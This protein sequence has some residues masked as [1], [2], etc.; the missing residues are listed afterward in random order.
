MPSI[1]LENL[2]VILAAIGAACFTMSGI[3]EFA[4]LRV[5][6]LSFSDVSISVA[7]ISAD[8]LIW[9]PAA[10]VGIVF[11]IPI[12]MYAPREKLNY[13]GRSKFVKFL[14]NSSGNSGLSIKFAA[15][16]GFLSYIIFGDDEH[17][18][19]V[20]ALALSANIALSHVIFQ[21]KIFGRNPIISICII[22]FSISATG[23]YLLGNTAGEKALEAPKNSIIYQDN[24]PPIKAHLARAYDKGYLIITSTPVYISRG[25]VRQIEINSHPLDRIG[26]P[27]YLFKKM[28]ATN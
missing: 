1:K 14:H 9:F 27:C 8:T 21:D 19:L 5:L 6:G 24:H 22:A 15:I 23:L 12:I 18:A 26:V 4:F 10:V 11:M 16:I 17:I 3:Y 13:Q 28:C 25:N 7:D 2:P 20:G